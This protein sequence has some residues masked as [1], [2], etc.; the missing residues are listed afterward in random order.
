MADKTAWTEFDSSTDWRIYNDG[1]FLR[2]GYTVTGPDSRGRVEVKAWCFT[3]WGAKWRIRKL[4]RKPVPPPF[5]E[6]PVAHREA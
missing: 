2:G 1:G 4:R 3:L 5:W 6:R